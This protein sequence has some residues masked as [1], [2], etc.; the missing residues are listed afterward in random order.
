MSVLTVSEIK[1][2]TVG[3]N[4]NQLKLSGDVDIQGASTFKNLSVGDVYWTNCVLQT[5]TMFT[6]SMGSYASNTYD[7]HITPLDI[8]I[9][10]TFQNSTIICQWM[11][12]GEMHQDNVFR[13]FKK[14]GTQLA[15]IAPNGTNTSVTQN[16][17][18]GF[19]SAFYD[20]NESSTPSNWFIQYI[21]ENVGSTVQTTY[22]IRTRS[23]SS[24]SRTFYLN[25]TVNSTGADAYENMCSTGVIWEIK[26]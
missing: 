10:P 23:S 25:R 17:W 12:N 15:G 21:D 1:G 5:K 6:D 9:T 20:Q 22:Q 14:S 26:R 24:G 3:N 13:I 19:V 18:V 7:N 11:V 8:T 4:L 2:Q 16:R